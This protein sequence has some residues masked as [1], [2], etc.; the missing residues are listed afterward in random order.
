MY[1]QI[2]F[3]SGEFHEIASV[4]P[5]YYEFTPKKL[6]IYAPKMVYI[7]PVKGS[8]WLQQVLCLRTPQETNL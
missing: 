2:A 4:F 1:L 7:E 6:A 5:S 3:A 8:E